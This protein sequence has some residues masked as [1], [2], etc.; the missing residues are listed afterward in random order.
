MAGA[1]VCYGPE[2]RP[3]RDTVSEIAVTKDGEL[4]ISPP[5][6]DPVESYPEVPGT[7]SHLYQVPSSG[8]TPEQR[9]RALNEA[10]GHLSKGKQHF[11]SSQ[12]DLQFRWD[13]VKE[14]VTNRILLGGGDPFVDGPC[15]LNLKWMERSVLDNFASLWRAKWPHN[16]ADPESYWGYVMSLDTTEAAYYC[17][18]NARDYLAGKFIDQKLSLSTAEDPRKIDVYSQGRYETTNSNAYAPV[19]FFTSE[20]HCSF[21]KAAHTVGL[22]TFYSIGVERYPGECPIDA[23]WPRY[24]PCE[25]GDAG[26]GNVDIDALGKLVDFFSGKG[27]PII[28]VFNYGSYFRA[29]C[30]DVKRAGEVLIPIL[31]RN[32]V[33]ERTLH[34][35]ST[36][37][38]RKGFW[39]HVDGVLSAVYMPFFEMAH[40]KG[41]IAEKPGPV[42]DFRLDFVTSLAANHHTWGGSPWH[43]AV[44][45]TRSNH[46]LRKTMSH[47]G[48]FDTVLSG[49]R[50]VISIVLLWTH[51]ASVD[52]T[53][54]VQRVVKRLSAVQKVEQKLKDI[55]SKIGG[56]LWIR[57]CPY[58]F[59]ICFRK[60]CNSIVEKYHLASQTLFIKGQRRD[61]VQLCQ[62][63]REGVESL[64]TDLERPSAFTAS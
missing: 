46:Q 19:V 43:C 1:D 16:P 48:F 21:L 35:N 31:K 12:G 7:T 39:F 18:R 22:H 54:Q 20:A 58:S 6:T 33:Y 34:V 63:D 28:V 41:L 4:L 44:Y 47:F 23:E 37:V 64:L 59:V 56:D 8:L 29:A 52:Y 14:Y 9:Q 57:R 61:Y 49:A 17:L 62:V 55:E 10:V 40:C 60:P 30:D 5:S 2:R 15:A 51:F 32:G 26:A 38:V 45:M 53:E 50:Y 11:L 3:W 36:C 42:F 25:G 24:V 27:H 13:S